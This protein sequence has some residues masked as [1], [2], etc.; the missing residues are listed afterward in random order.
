MWNRIKPQGK[1]I[2]NRL[3]WSEGCHA[4]KS[5][6]KAKTKKRVPATSK[7]PKNVWIMYGT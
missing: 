5:E 7:P 6:C 3:T 2:K 1:K 4:D